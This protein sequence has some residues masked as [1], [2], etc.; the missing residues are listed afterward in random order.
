VIPSSTKP[1]NQAANLEALRLRL[2]D[3]DMARIATLDRG[4]R[5]ANPDFAPAWD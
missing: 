5:L 3:D 1:A 4:E 2:S